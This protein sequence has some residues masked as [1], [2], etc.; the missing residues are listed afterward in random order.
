VLSV[1]AIGTPIGFIIFIFSNYKL[2]KLNI[3]RAL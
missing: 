3:Y 2:N 1:V